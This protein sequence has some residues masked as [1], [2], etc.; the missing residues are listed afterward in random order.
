MILGVIPARGGSSLKGK[1]IRL[2]CGKP[3]IHWIIDAALHSNIDHLVVSTDDDEIADFADSYAGVLTR[4]RPK[5]ISGPDSPSEAA[6]ND[7]IDTFGLEPDKTILLQATTPTTSPR[8]INSLINLLDKY[9]SAFLAWETSSLLWENGM[10][11]NP[12]LGRM[13]QQR[14]QLEEAGIYA[15][16]GRVDSRFTGNVGIHVTEKGIDINDEIDFVL[17][18]ALLNSV[19]RT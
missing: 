3:L 15:W 6:V 1:N 13:R 8:D 12:S 9:D 7:V 10:P 19:R 4:W 14:M 11:V 17:A 18:E 2:L 16:N 5:E